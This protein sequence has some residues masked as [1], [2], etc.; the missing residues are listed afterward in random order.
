MYAASP[1][2]LA[3]VLTHLWFRNVTLRVLSCD[4]GRINI[5]D[6][7]GVQLQLPSSLLSDL[8]PGAEVIAFNQPWDGTQGLI[9]TFD[10]VPHT[11]P[12]T[13]IQKAIELN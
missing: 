11:I 2:M 1:G 13:R 10:G 5:G 8:P 6:E 12:L 4:R 7:G 3:K 9:S